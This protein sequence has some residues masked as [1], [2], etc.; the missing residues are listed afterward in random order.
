VNTPQMIRAIPAA[1]ISVTMSPL[2]GAPLLRGP[3]HTDR[4]LP[5]RTLVP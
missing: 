5:P 4:R 3:H 2:N 1:M